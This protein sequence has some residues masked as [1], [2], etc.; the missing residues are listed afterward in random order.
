MPI[1]F[2]LCHCRSLLNTFM[3]EVEVWAC[4]TSR[5]WL[6]YDDQGSHAVTHVCTGDS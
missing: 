4:G 6:G 2:V 3:V 1:A 5:A